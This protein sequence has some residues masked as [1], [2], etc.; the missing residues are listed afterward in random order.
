[1]PFSILCTGSSGLVASDFKKLALSEN[2]PFYGLDLHGEEESVDITNKEPVLAYINSKLNLISDKSI[3]ILFHFAAITITGNNLTS[4]Q[5]DISKKVNIDATRILLE[6]CKQLSIPLVY[7]STDFVFAGGKKETPYLPDDEICPDNTIYSQ[8]KAEAEKL[9]K[10]ASKDQKVVIIRLAFPYGN[11]SHPKPGL[12]RKMISWMDNNAEVKLYND[13]FICPTPIS[14]FSDCCLQIAQLISEDKLKTG[15]VLHCVGQTTT[16]Y[17]FGSLIKEVFEK[18]AKL[19]PTSIGGGVKNL[20][21][22]TDK[23]EKILNIVKPHH[24][25]SIQSL[26][27][28]C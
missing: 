21:L 26:I 8:T 1:M 27:D 25:N 17:E 20:V 14:Y 10:N 15:Q 16:P 28:Q 5:I 23:T 6:A 3:P 18:K 7:I 12:A 2:I 19:V 4:D 11:F 9:V 22:N 13:Q 24:Q